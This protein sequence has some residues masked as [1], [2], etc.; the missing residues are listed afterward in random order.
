MGLA[1]APR[2]RLRRGRRRRVRPDLRF[3]PAGPPLLTCPTTFRAVV[4]TTSCCR[5]GRRLTRWQTLRMLDHISIQCADIAKSAAF[6]DAVLTPLGGGRVMDFGGAIG[7]GIPPM[8]TFWIG[9]QETGEGF[10]E[11]HIAFSAARPERRPRL[12]RCRRRGGRRGPPRAA[13]LARVPP[14]LLR[15]LRPR[16]RREQRRS[17]LPHP[18][19]GGTRLRSPL[20]ASTVSASRRSAKR[21]C[22]SSR[23]VGMCS[24]GTSCATYPFSTRRATVWRCT[25][26]GPS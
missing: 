5:L 15:R 8:P 3:A 2:H 10:R 18:G 20:Y 17:G 22:A 26:S 12:L 4:A 14:Q 9:A 24:D 1:R 25:S 13:P 23:R 16:S 11:S 19:V 7:Y 6:Y 21:R